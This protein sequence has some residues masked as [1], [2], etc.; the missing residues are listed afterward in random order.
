MSALPFQ[1]SC[2]LSHHLV[3]LQMCKKLECR[4][5]LKASHEGQE[6][7]NSLGTEF[8]GKGHVS[9]CGEEDE[10]SLQKKKNIINFPIG[11][12]GERK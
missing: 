5:E 9:I 6:H 12:L 2:F 1:L 11:L 7:H 3:P 4:N 10:D 8:E